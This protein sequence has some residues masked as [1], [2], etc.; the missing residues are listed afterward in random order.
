[1]LK[2]LLFQKA[3][4]SGSNNRHFLFN[5]LKNDN[6]EEFLTVSTFCTFE[7]T[8]KTILWKLLYRDAL[9]NI[10]L[11]KYGSYLKFILLLSV[12]LSLNSGNTTQQEKIYHANFFLS[13]TV[14]FLLSG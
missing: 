9:S 8:E 4:L 13:T 5:T 7:L 6:K 3:K 10:Y 11:N 2:V 12:E 1:M 14:V